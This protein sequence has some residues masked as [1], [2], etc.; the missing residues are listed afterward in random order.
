AE[1]DRAAFVIHLPQHFSRSL[2]AELLLVQPLTQSPIST[3]PVPDLIWLTISDDEE[4]EI[5]E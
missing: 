4:E 1:L 5:K 2:E 3:P